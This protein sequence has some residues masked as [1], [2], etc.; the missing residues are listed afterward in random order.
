[1]IPII[2]EF[3]GVS[4]LSN[5]IADK[6]AALCT[7]MESSDWSPVVVKRELRCLLDEVMMLINLNKG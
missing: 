3:D 1:M 5:D 2:E 6:L 7:H 4:I